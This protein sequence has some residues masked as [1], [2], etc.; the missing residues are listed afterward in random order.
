M[1]AL[2]GTG[3]AEAR[4]RSLRG[5]AWPIAGAV[6]LGCALVALCVVLYTRNCHPPR[7][8]FENLTLHDGWFVATV[9]K[10]I[11][12]SPPWTLLSALAAA[13]AVLLTWFWRTAHKEEDIRVANENTRIAQEQQITGR[14]VGA[15]ELLNS[16]GVPA[17]L[18][19]IYALEH[20]V[21]DSHAY[22]PTVVKTLSAFVRH[23]PGNA[24]R[25]WFLSHE[26]PPGAHTDVKPEMDVEAALSVLVELGKLPDGVRGSARPNLQGARLAGANLCYAHLKGAMLQRVDLRG[27]DL[28]EVSMGGAHLE[29]A[30][31]TGASFSSARLEGVIMMG[32]DLQRAHFESADL[33]GAILER[34]NLQGAQ[35][36]SAVLVG[37]ILQGADLADADLEGAN[38]RGAKLGG[39]KL[40]GAKL[41]GALYDDETTFPADFDP[42]T[43]G[44]TWR[45]AR[46]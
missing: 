33:T 15:A 16:D 14:Y 20:I 8:S 44:M 34:V 29:W 36:G 5:V 31:L 6:L 2:P 18:G 32:A 10:P 43:A 30:I 4:E 26:R 21:R 45:P 22:Y 23:A 35:L 40:G 46:A 38:L 27:A 3:S 13:P 17:R 28:Q 9:C 25:E 1:E 41:A 12:S 11:Q 7:G 37:A 19:G 39:A 24:Q 42:V